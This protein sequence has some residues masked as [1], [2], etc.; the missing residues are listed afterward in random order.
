[1]YTIVDIETT[2]LSRKRHKITEIAA[3]KFDGE[4]IT[5]KFETLINPLCNI[6]PKIVRLTGITNEMVSD[7]PC[8]E[9]KIKE[10][11]SFLGNDIFVG[12]N[13]TFD[14]N[15]LDHNLNRHFGNN[16]ENDKLCTMRLSRRLVPE[17]PN[18]KLSTI[19]RYFNLKHENA[20]RAMAD[21][22]VTYQILRE[23]LNRLHKK[24]IKERKKI[25]RFQS[26]KIP[27]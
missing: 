8:I 7:A 25:L 15:F 12:H 6:P 5:G 4:R 16:L 20:H 21:V 11:N 23:F 26:S 19:T 3:L 2:G 17:L 10:F 27:R 9:E 14:Y 24:D 18:N 1:M 13:A 22:K